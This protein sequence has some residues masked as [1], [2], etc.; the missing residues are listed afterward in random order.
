MINEPPVFDGAIQE[1]ETCL[2]PEVAA[3]P[4]GAPGTVYGVVEA[5]VAV[6]VPAA[7]CAK[8]SKSY[9]DPFV[10]PPTTEDVAVVEVAKTYVE[11]ASSLS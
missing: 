2:S 7:F 11:D 6:E 8:I 10:R 4:V 9:S 5:K 3:R 1:R